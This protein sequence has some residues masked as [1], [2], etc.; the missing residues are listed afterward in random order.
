MGGLKMSILD[1]ARELGAELSDSKELMSLREA[2]EMMLRNPDAQEA[3]KEFNEKQQSFQ[4][5]Q[6]QGFPLTEGQKKE[7]EDLELKMLDN[8]YVYNFFKAQQD[9]YKI[10]EAVNDIIGEAIG[11]KQQ[12]CNCECDCGDNSCE[13]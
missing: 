13:N 3:I 9:F 2:E 6:S 1:K 12:G 10:L 8:P 4:V 11:M 7:L 5:I